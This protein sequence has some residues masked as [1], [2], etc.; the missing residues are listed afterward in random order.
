MN[1]T[2]RFLREY[3]KAVRAGISPEALNSGFSADQFK[4]MRLGKDHGIDHSLYSFPEVSADKMRTVRK[5]QEMGVKVDKKLLE[6]YSDEQLNEIRLG[7]KFGIDT[8]LYQNPMLD[9][10]DMRTL[11]L[12]SMAQKIVESIKEKAQELYNSIKNNFLHGSVQGEALENAVQNTLEKQTFKQLQLFNVDDYDNLNQ[13]RDFILEKYNEKESIENVQN[14]LPK[15]HATDYI[16]HDVSEVGG[17][18]VAL[19]Q[20]SGKDDF[21]VAHQYQENSTIADWKDEQHFNTKEAAASHYQNYL[22]SKITNKQVILQDH[23]ELSE[24]DKS[25]MKEIESLS[26]D[27]KVVDVKRLENFIALR[28]DITLEEKLE[29]YQNANQIKFHPFTNVEPIPDTLYGKLAQSYIE[30]NGYMEGMVKSGLYACVNLD[31]F[32]KKLVDEHK[33]VLSEEGYYEFN[34]HEEGN[35]QKQDSVSQPKVQEKITAI[36][37]RANDIAALEEKFNTSARNYSEMDMNTKVNIDLNVN[38]SSIVKNLTLTPKEFKALYYKGELTQTSAF[39]ELIKGQQI[40]LQEVQESV[41]ISE[42]S[43]PVA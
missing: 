19:M 23:A 1:Y 13:V 40:S 36:H 42:A 6:I 18:K 11:R 8:K 39:Q 28:K 38:E 37:I 10:D 33:L 24:K 29:V 4:E 5:L 31:D 35:V 9:A 32:G 34:G 22:I 41:E 20:V 2:N 21:F 27:M 15:E 30:S 12:L 17:E 43:I 25:I 3:T 14:E 16:R 7:E 26:N